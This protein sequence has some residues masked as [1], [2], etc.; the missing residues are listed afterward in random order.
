MNDGGSEG[1]GAND[2]SPGRRRRLARPT[3][4]GGLATCNGPPVRV[5]VAVPFAVQIGKCGGRQ[6]TLTAEYIHFHLDVKLCPA[7]RHRS[8]SLVSTRTRYR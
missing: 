7:R 3:F 1:R 4:L 6:P 8:V 2:P 5:A